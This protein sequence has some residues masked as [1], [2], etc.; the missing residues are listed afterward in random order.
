MNNQLAFSLFNKAKANGAVVG[1]ENYLYEE[2]YIKA[3]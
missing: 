3:Y 1:K 2:N